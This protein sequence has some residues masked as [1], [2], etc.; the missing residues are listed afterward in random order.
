[1]MREPI[2]M[3]RLGALSEFVIF[4]LQMLRNM[5]RYIRNNS[6]FKNAS[7]VSHLKL[8]LLPSEETRIGCMH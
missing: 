2:I 5:E 8:R 7:K 6:M 3:L 4:E 1:M